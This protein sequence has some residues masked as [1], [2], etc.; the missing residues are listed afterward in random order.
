M[1]CLALAEERDPQGHDSATLSASKAHE[2][3]RA[4]GASLAPRSS[5]RCSTAGPSRS[6]AMASRHA[7][8]P[9]STEHRQGHLRVDHHA[10]GTR[11]GAQ[12]RRQRP[13][14]DL[15]PWRYPCIQGS[16]DPAAAAR[17]DGFRTTSSPGATRT[18]GTASRTRP[19]PSGFSA[20]R[21]RGNWRKGSRGQPGVAP[22]ST[23]W[24][25]QWRHE[26]ILITLGVIL[27]NRDSRRRLA[28]LSAGLA[29]PTAPADVRA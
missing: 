14:H 8:S 18:S 17:T 7:P 5:R 1:L 23:T 10:G 29:A 3:I 19:E 16:R 11:R 15:R 24:K 21:R 28:A 20:S 4:G 25:E 9:T 6:A 2:T 27:A 22:G 26:A 12:H 13:P